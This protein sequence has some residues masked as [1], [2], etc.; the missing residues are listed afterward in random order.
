MVGQKLTKLAEIFASDAVDLIERRE[1]AIRIHK[2]DIR[3]AGNEVEISVREYLKRLLTRKYYVGHGHLIDRNEATSPQID[4][5]FSDNESLPSLLKTQD[6]TEFVPYDSVFSIG[7]IKSTFYSSEKPIRQFSEKISKIRSNLSREEIPN[8]IYGGLKNTS[9]IR[10]ILLARQGPTLNRLLS[11]LF[12]VDKGD[13]DLNKVKDEFAGMDV[14]DAPS[15]V[16]F[17]NLGVLLFGKME[18]GSFIFTRYPAEKISED[19]RWYLC[20]FE[21]VEEGSLEGNHLAFLYYSLVEHL[22]QSYLEPPSLG[23]YVAKMLKGRRTTL[24]ELG[25]GSTP[26]E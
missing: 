24:T 15:F 9:L 20:P 21:K 11:F 8:T 17:L 6:G 14:R 1:K 3:A 13:L 16:V 5:I 23:R 7:E 4:A 22:S 2:T 18:E 19:F 10:D 12:F 26:T 25:D